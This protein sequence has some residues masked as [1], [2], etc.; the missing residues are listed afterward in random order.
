MR[1]S[2]VKADHSPQDF[3]SETVMSADE[4]NA[5]QRLVKQVPASDTW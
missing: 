1:S 3:I 2:V 4:I 5:F